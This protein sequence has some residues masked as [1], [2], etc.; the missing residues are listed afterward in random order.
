MSR[1]LS[2]SV[3]WAKAMS[4]NS[5]ANQRSCESVACFDNLAVMQRSKLGA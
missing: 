1:R 2:R 4:R 3:N 5:S